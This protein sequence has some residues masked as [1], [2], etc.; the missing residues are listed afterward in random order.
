MPSLLSIIMAILIASTVRFAV[1]AQ[2]PDAKAEALVSCPIVFQAGGQ[3][4]DV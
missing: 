3:Q 2:T 1:N 4:A